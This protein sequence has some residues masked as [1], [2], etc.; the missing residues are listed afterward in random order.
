MEKDLRM[1]KWHLKVLKPY[2][3]STAFKSIKELSV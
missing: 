1:F 2:K 3:P